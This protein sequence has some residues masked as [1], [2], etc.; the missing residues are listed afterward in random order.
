MLRGGVSREEQQHVSP[1]T[2][3]TAILILCSLLVFWRLVIWSPSSAAFSRLVDL[4]FVTA[5]G[6]GGWLFRSGRPVGSFSFVML[7]AGSLL[8]FT[9]NP[10]PAQLYSSG[11]QVAPF[12]L[13]AMKGDLRYVA[14][15]VIIVCAVIIAYFSALQLG[16]MPG[17]EFFGPGDSIANAAFNGVSQAMLCGWAVWS[18][19]RGLMEQREIAVRESASKQRLWQKVT[20]E[21]RTPL[22]G[23]LGSSA[24]LKRETDSPLLNDIENC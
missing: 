7:Y 23:V 4:W 19:S 8:V 15:V 12:L 2:R 6:V 5:F 21:L 22:L 1:R 3:N 13:V 16:Y 9:H 17:L 20:H 18:M 14:H 24:L 11:L 10:T